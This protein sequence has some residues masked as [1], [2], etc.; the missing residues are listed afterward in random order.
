L[1]PAAYALQ[2]RLQ[3]NDADAKSDL[4]NTKDFWVRD[5]MPLHRKII[6]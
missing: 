4:L 6:F 2:L 1:R 5:F 3:K